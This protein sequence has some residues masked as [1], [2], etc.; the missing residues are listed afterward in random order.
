MVDAHT[1]KIPPGLRVE[2]RMVKE[3]YN[4]SG[5]VIFL[6][7]LAVRVVDTRGQGYDIVWDSQEAI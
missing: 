2:W 1:F 6:E 7:L 4:A 5:M 3:H